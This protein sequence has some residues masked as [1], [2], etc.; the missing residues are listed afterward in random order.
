MN[1]APFIVN[2]PVICDGSWHLCPGAGGGGK[3][4]AKQAALG[5]PPTTGTNEP[6]L[7]RVT[8]NPDRPAGPGSEL[9]RSRI[10]FQHQHISLCHE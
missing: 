9:P 2:L 3:R 1:S 4:R 7:I 10:S 8:K 6:L 5:A